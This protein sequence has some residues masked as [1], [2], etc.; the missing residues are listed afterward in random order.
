[1]SSACV[2]NGI[3][4]YL[5]SAYNVDSAA[6]PSKPGKP[7]TAPPTRAS[8]RPDGPNKEL[9][10]AVVAMKQRNPSWGCPRIA[11]QIALAFGVEID[12]DVVRRILSAHY[13]PESPHNFEFAMVS[14]ADLRARANTRRETQTVEHAKVRLKKSGTICER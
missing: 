1:M 12:K 4:I 7:A 8:P 2:G 5:S 6:D 11:Q 13:R 10:D 9:I 14:P 3:K